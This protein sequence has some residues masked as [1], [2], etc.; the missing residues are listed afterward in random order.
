MFEK[1]IWPLDLNGPRGFLSGY[2]Q[3]YDINFSLL[4]SDFLVVF[5]DRLEQGAS[6]RRVG[7]VY[8]ELCFSL[9]LSGRV[10]C[11]AHQFYQKCGF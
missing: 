7:K 5:I 11:P 4:L 3:P 10:V 8:F 2:V 9:V 1:L 6:Q